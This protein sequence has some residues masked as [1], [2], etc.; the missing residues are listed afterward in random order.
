MQ[1]SEPCKCTIRRG[2]CAFLSLLCTE[3]RQICGRVLHDFAERWS[4]GQAPFSFLNMG[5]ARFWLL[6]QS[7]YLPHGFGKAVCAALPPTRKSWPKGVARITLSGDAPRS[8]HIRFELVGTN[9]LTSNRVNRH[10]YKHLLLKA[11]SYPHLRR[12]GSLYCADLNCAYCSSRCSREPTKR[13]KIVTPAAKR[14]ILID[15]RNE[16]EVPE[17]VAGKVRELRARD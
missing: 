10:K 17:P 14:P 11:I 16:A 12:V 4:C 1:V 9:D 13:V 15:G 8:S 2:F 6:W 7:R 5:A 3:I